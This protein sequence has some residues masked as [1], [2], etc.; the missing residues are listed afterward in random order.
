MASP[1]VPKGREELLLRTPLTFGFTGP[2]NMYQ[3]SNS[4]NYV[5]WSLGLVMRLES[6]RQKSHVTWGERERG[7][8]ER[9]ERQ[10]ER[11]EREGGREGEGQR[12]VISLSYSRKQFAV[13][14]VQVVRGSSREPESRGCPETHHTPVNTATLYISTVLTVCTIPY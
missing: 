9:E 8:R 1:F 7:K 6:C 10:R 13:I 3:P 4:Q 5:S 2:S 11:G 14:S 12:G